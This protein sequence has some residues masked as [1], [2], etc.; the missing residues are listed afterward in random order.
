MKERGKPA[1]E[2]LRCDEK[3]LAECQLVLFV[4]VDG[5]DLGRNSGCGSDWLGASHESTS[6]EMWIVP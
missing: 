2:V 5:L 3:G 4:L 6:Q 1:K